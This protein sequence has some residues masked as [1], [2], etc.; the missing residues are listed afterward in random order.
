MVFLNIASV[1]QGARMI[2]SIQAWELPS[3]HVGDFF[4][5]KCC[6]QNIQLGLD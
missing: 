6:F 5:F 4:F 1:I 2:K 3:S